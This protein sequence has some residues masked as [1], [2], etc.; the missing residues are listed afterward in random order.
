MSKYTPQ[1]KSHI[2]R[3]S[4]T[5]RIWFGRLFGR[6]EGA[7]ELVDEFQSI[8]AR[9]PFAPSF[10]THNDYF[11]TGLVAF[12]M[13]RKDGSDKEYWDNIASDVMKKFDTWIEIGSDWNFL[14]KMQMLVAERAYCKRDVDVA[15]AAYDEAI[16]AAEK[17]GF[18]H[19]EALACELAGIFYCERGDISGGRSYLQKSV[20]LFTRWGAHRK[21][22]H[23][24]SVL[25]NYHT[26]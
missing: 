23:V 9:N 12:A 4:L 18:I 6:Y 21:A 24:R 22:I 25:Q 2:K 20:E 14:S 16:A 10:D 15:K 26:S 17:H 1:A 19:E 8:A 13:L 3:K 11:Y 5:F 7:K